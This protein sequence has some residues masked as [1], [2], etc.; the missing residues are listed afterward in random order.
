MPIN[1]SKF[2]NWSAC[3]VWL[4]DYEGEWNSLGHK[5]HFLIDSWNTHNFIDKFI[6]KLECKI[7]PSTHVI[8]M[9]ADG[10]NFNVKKSTFDWIGGS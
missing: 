4:L 1:F 7:V 5:I 2:F 3:I 9:V 8:V 6:E 10:N